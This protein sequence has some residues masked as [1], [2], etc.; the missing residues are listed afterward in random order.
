MYKRQ[1]SN[2]EMETLAHGNFSCISISRRGSID[3]VILHW[4][5]IIVMAQNH[6]SDLRMKEV[7]EMLNHAC[8]VLGDASD[9]ARIIG[10]YNGHP[11]STVRFT[12]FASESCRSSVSELSGAISGVQAVLA[13]RPSALA[14]YLA[15]KVLTYIASLLRGSNYRLEHSDPD[16]EQKTSFRVKFSP[17]VKFSFSSDGKDDKAEKNKLI[18]KDSEPYEMG[19]SFE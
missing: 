13:F 3:A 17:T 15:T 7:A 19:A 10:C 8:T 4:N 14:T 1:H 5:G 2:T 9:G 16:K 18:L 11:A 12:V 6:R